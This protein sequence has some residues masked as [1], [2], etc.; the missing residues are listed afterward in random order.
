[1]SQKKSHK[2]NNVVPVELGSAVLVP[3]PETQADASPGVRP[4]QVQ[5]GPR[6]QRSPLTLLS[7]VHSTKPTAL[8]LLTCL[9]RIIPDPRQHLQ[10]G[11]GNL[12]RHS[13]HTHLPRPKLSKKRGI[14]IVSAWWDSGPAPCSLPPT[15]L[16][17]QQITPETLRHQHSRWIILGTSGTGAQ[18]H[19]S[20]KWPPRAPT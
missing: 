6:R 16:R 4:E 20:Q 18:Q 7:T 15:C 8:T 19:R 3:A 14:A 5:P 13:N 10:Q 12:P 1:M 2:N 17:P 9:Q 11:P